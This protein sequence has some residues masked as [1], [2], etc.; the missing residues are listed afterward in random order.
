MAQYSVHRN[1]NL[2]TNQTIPFLLNVQADQLDHL[3]SRV[4]VPLVRQA[5]M[6]LPAKRLNPCFMIDGEAVV[7]SS[8]ELAGIPLRA[9]GEEVASL[10]DHRNDILAAL[11]LLLTGI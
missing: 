3:A 8:A 6:P 1:P 5:H 7:M 9:I 2:N 4:V 10:A 11:D